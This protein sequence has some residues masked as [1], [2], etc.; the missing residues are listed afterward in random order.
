[1]NLQTKSTPKFT[2]QT[3]RFSLTPLAACL[4]GVF[5]LSATPLA[6]AIDP[7]ALPTNGQVAAGSAVIT[8]QGAKMNVQQDS[9]RVILNW[10]SFNIGSAASVNFNQPSTSSVALNRVNAGGGGSEIA[11]QLSANGQVFL[12]NAAGVLFSPTAQVNVG[13]IVASSL[14]ISDAD[15]IAS[16]YTF[17]SYS[18][19]SGVGEVANMGSISAKNGSII[20]LGPRV[21]NDGSI[22]NTGGPVALVSGERIRLDMRG[23]QLIGLDV[24]QGTLAGSVANSGRIQAD[25]SAVW[26]QAKAA[27]DI[28]SAVVNNTGVIQ[29]QTV[30]N[31]GGVIKLLAEGGTTHVAGT[32]DA[33]APVN[34]NG[35]FIETSGDKVTVS[36]SAHVTT[37]AANGKYGQWLI[38]PV[39]FNI[40]AGGGDMTG[41]ALSTALD[42]N[43]FSVLSVNG[44]EG[45]TGNINVNDSVT[46]SAP[47]TLTLRA[48]NNVNIMSPIMGSHTNSRVEA[49]AGIEGTNWA[50]NIS[51]DIDV[52]VGGSITAGSIH[53]QA[54]NATALDAGADDFTRF[55]GGV[56]IRASLT[57]TG[58]DG[59]T[60]ISGNGASGGTGNGSGGGDIGVYAP[61]NAANGLIQITTGNGADTVSGSGG[62]GGSVGIGDTSLT[63]KGIYITAGNGGIGNNE[64]FGGDGGRITISGVTINATG[65][66]GVT[67]VAGNGGQSSGSGGSIDVTDSSTINALDGL[68]RMTAGKGADAVGRRAGGSGGDV[69]VDIKGS[70]SFRAKGISI[71][72][73]NGGNGG[74][75]VSSY[76]LVSG[77]NG[78]S[79]RITGA[80]ISATAIQG[81]T[82]VAG[83]GGQGGQGPVSNE[84]YSGISGSSGG[85]GGQIRL[86]G[87][88]ITSDIG[89]ISLTAGNGG[90]GG[91]GAITTTGFSKGGSGG[92][93]GIIRISGDSSITASMETISLKAG[94]GGRGGIGGVAT[95]G[96]DS[97]ASGGFPADGGS[98]GGGGNIEVRNSSSIT[99][100]EKSI[101]MRAGDG[102]MGGNGGTGSVGRRGSDGGYYYPATNGGYGGSAYGGRGGSAGSVNISRSSS[103]LAPSTS[104]GIISLNAGIG[105]IGGNGGTAGMGG[106]G[107]TG[108]AGE[109]GYGVGAGGQGG[110]GG[111]AGAGFG[112][113]GG[114]VANTAWVEAGTRINMTATPNAQSGASNGTAGAGGA[115]GLGGGSGTN[116]E[117]GSAGNADPVTGYPQ[118]GSIQSAGS[119]NSNSNTKAP[120]LVLDSAGGISSGCGSFVSEASE[121]RAT[122]SHSGSILIL[123]TG[124]VKI[125][126]RNDAEDISGGY[127]SFGRGDGIKIETRNS[128]PQF[129]AF[130]EGSSSGTAQNGADI[131][132]TTVS[133]LSGIY[134]KTGNVVLQASNGSIIG[135]E[136]QQIF[137]SE[138]QTTHGADG[139]HGGNGGSIIINQPITAAAG[140]VFVYAGAGASGAGGGSGGSG[141]SGEYA[142]FGPGNGG[143]GGNGGMGGSITVNASGVVN[144]PLDR[145]EMNAGYGGDGGRGGN[146]GGAG[147]IVGFAS[148]VGGMGG[149]AGA[150]GSIVVNSAQT[151]KSITLQAGNAGYQGAGGNGGSGSFGGGAG[152][153]VGAPANGG[154]ISGSPVLTATDG[155]VRLSG[156]AGSSSNG[157]TGGQG[158]DGSSHNPSGP[159]APGGNGGA[160]R[161]G[162][163]GG[164][165]DLGE[166]SISAPSGSVFVYAGAGGNSAQG[167]WG[168]EAGEGVT[169]GS[170]G[171][172]GASNFSG[173][174]GGNIAV[175]AVQSGGQI[176][177]L[178][179]LPGNRLNEGGAPIGKVGDVTLN[180]ALTVV[181]DEDLYGDAI[182]IQSRVFTNYAGA[183]ALVVPEES[184][185]LVLSEKPSVNTF[186]GLQSGNFAVWNHDIALK[187]PELSGNRFLFTSNPGDAVVNAPSVVK[188]YGNTA[189]ISYQLVSHNDGAFYGNA[190]TDIATV[191][192]LSG[193]PFS[194]AGAAGTATVNGG[195]AGGNTYAITGDL[196]GV[197]ATSNE[198]PVNITLGT[199]GLV[200]VNQRQLGVT[201]TG[202]KI[203]DGNTTLI[204]PVFSLSN[205]ANGDAVSATGSA[206]FD[207]ASAGI[208]KALT[209]T[210]ISFSSSN[211]KE[212][213]Y[214]L[215]TMASGEG[216]TGSIDKRPLNVVADAQTK[217]YGNADPVLTYALGE[218]NGYVGSDNAG[219]V[220]AGALTRTAGENVADGPRAITQ[221]SLVA[222]NT[223]YAI[224]SYTGANLAI[225]ARPL[226][227]VADAKTKIY[228]NADPALT[229]ALTY[230]LGEGPVYVGSDNAG[231]VFAGALTRT[232]GE[233]VADGPRAITQGSLVASNTNYAI[234]SYTGANLAI[235]A[236]P[237]NVVA[238]AKTKI[239]GNADPALTYALG[240]GN[241]Y[242]GSD[243]AGTVFAGA[244][245]RTA[246][247]NVADGPRAITQGSL[248]ASNTNYAIGSYTGANLTITPKV[249]TLTSNNV[250]KVYGD[251]DPALTYAVSGLVGAD[252]AGMTGAL[253][254]AP[255]EAVAGFPYAINQ[256]SL[257][258]TNT[259]YSIGTYVSGVF[260]ITPAPLNVTA[261]DATRMEGTANPVFSAVITGMRGGDTVGTASSGLFITTPALTGSAAGDYAIA[262]GGI[263]NANYVV[264]YV[265]GVLKITALPS[266]PSVVYYETVIQSDEAKNSG[267]LPTIDPV[268]QQ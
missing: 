83:N 257:V 33:S 45:S 89:P 266:N 198:S 135:N 195:I 241:G 80:D 23:D 50:G 207:S 120:L 205:T 108:N 239:Y 186:G 130:S 215:P 189:N 54:G 34:G 32:L 71:T 47:T 225:T 218:G 191:T 99:A 87:S 169:P 139:S 145:I 176:E 254:R 199:V 138:Q 236:R 142:S 140:N 152:G 180:G 178:A 127:R 179:G 114:S 132:V 63:A 245:T 67:L 222:S 203:Y 175:S 6:L 242:V 220:F 12:I 134:A 102:G 204:S 53:L 192:S 182:S 171:A 92:S 104:A 159:G 77:G 98:G 129:E 216:N 267:S 73:G 244:L 149:A 240:A 74:N 174:N 113:S 84:S 40:S 256:G 96:G 196:T 110:Q 72:A 29:A 231:T 86:S 61:I 118:H 70:L 128:S 197:T 10:T 190:Y 255:G 62:A 15:F 141:Y 154:S 123:N 24:D 121:I 227:V 5:A 151:A 125:A 167:G 95:T 246:G 76:D 158:G 251:A 212:V 177:L 105:G 161:E 187:S 119:Y 48:I 65:T 136:L 162:G 232:A 150:G 69:G 223:N 41:A 260:T 265:N 66:Q 252:S 206:S 85:N 49:Y 46:W 213:N 122:N 262:P 156:G 166:G 248:V 117:S 91:N 112:G 97:Y 36:D 60:L 124:S 17:D 43:N 126:A 81:I 253:S 133:G 106:M 157:S 194:S 258:R 230:A 233:N 249:L 268:Q 28:A 147:S 16:R 30:Q 88:A 107:G 52:R 3:P 184:R 200:T 25:G 214:I 7:T 226:N 68:I 11:G 51:G 210:G 116:G 2:G 21:R 93:G 259:N 8:T 109:G 261:N 18:R 56:F 75:A 58:T 168:G 39:D 31:V 78:G 181:A 19:N 170:G 164:S 44:G 163:N 217:I 26:L 160:G 59:V 228:G 148:G 185:W 243:N 1:M 137:I 219:T 234:G 229:Y 82:L 64:S 37:K 20:L 79:I 193:N 202:T 235:T 238:D 111:N 14:N 57:A 188:T 100:T 165:I 27:G 153:A 4:A 42:N 143:K 221:G 22:V 144:A 90:Q 155:D 183:N 208:S 247:E 173:G 55:G 209:G 101:S 211:G 250:S 35:G 201:V 172:T 38:D 115:G 9:A 131:E 103:I 13:G 263:T 264:T 94:N 146:A 224:G 237:L